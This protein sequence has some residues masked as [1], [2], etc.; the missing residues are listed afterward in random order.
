[1]ASMPAMKMGDKQGQDDMKDIGLNTA[2]MPT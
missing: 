1:M 2:A